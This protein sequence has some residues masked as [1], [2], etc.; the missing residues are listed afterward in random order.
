MTRQQA[1]A[2]MRNLINAHPALRDAGVW[3][4]AGTRSI[5]QTNGIDCGIFVIENGL[6]LM[7]GEIAAREVNTYAARRRLAH[8]LLNQAVTTH[9]DALIWHKG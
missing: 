7:D 4:E 1:F 5:R 8:E 2:S 6:A 3:Q 9:L